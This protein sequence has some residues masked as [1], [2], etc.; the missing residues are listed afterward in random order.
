MVPDDEA[1]PERRGTSRF[2]LLGDSNAPAGPRDLIINEIATRSRLQRRRTAHPKNSTV[3]GRT[4]RLLLTFIV[5][6][7][8][9]AAEGFPLNNL[10]ERAAGLI[11]RQRA[12]AAITEAL[13]QSGYKSLDAQ[14]QAL[15]LSRSTAWT[16]IRRKHKLG[17]LHTNTAM[18]MLASPALPV[19]VRAAIEAYVSSADR[20]AR[21]GPR[22]ANS[23][24]APA[25]RGVRPY[26][27]APTVRA[28][29]VEIPSPRSTVN[30]CGARRQ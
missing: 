8:A 30:R 2:R 11:A 4:C 1:R 3:R 21:P 7:M 13:V 23:E 18:K 5:R 28:E 16:V 10:S 14:A 25:L 20:D 12:V 9:S 27:E 22:V 19:P 17:R 29:L 6:R 26:A 15:G 24:G